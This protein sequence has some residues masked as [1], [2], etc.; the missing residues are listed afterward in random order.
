MNQITQKLKEAL[1]GTEYEN[2]LYLVG[3]AIRDNL[4][5][6]THSKDLDFVT[7]RN[8][9][10]LAEF[11]YSINLSDIQPVVYPRFGTAMIQIDG[12]SV[13]LVTA[14]SEKYQFDSRK[15][16][17]TPGTYEDDAL[18]RDF[19][20]NTLMVNIFDGTL[21]DPLSVGLD[22][23]KEGVLDTPIDA[24]KTFV[25]D[26]LRMLRAIRFKNKF[27]LDPSNAVWKA[28][29]QNAERLK[30]ISAERIQEE[31]VKMLALP[32]STACLM[33]LMNTGLLGQ[34]APEFLPLQGLE[35]G[36]FHDSDAWNHTLR[37][38]H[39]VGNDD[40]V[41]CLAALM[42]DIAKPLTKSVDEAGETHFYRHEIIGAEVARRIL[43]RLKFSNDIVDEVCLLI[44]NHMRLSTRERPGKSA[45]RRLIRDL[46][47]NLDRLILLAKADR[48]AHVV[49]VADSKGIQRIYEVICEV[50]EETPIKTL[51]SPIDGVE[52]MELLGI[53]PG[54]EV[55]WIKN[56][57][58][59]MV[60]DG[61]LLYEDKERAKE[62]AKE[63]YEN[64]VQVV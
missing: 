15:P 60:L 22:H 27:D 37:V 7:T 30:M 31:L 33:D 62:L 32:K 3:G 8:A 42:H 54:K 18:R 57:L 58:T 23:L 55:G 6:L 19:T 48:G 41:L 40:L 16:D 11:L 38:V 51:Q 12:V 59:E 2:E 53:G 61:T 44:R 21:K 29:T 46:D 20:I 43:R 39:N 34:F 47:T 5:G 17:V 14:R 36:K 9:I 25:D 26:P 50:R 13:E 4:L 64:P 1:T 56:T 52:I 63:F 49:N 10:H 24:N 35:Q 28:I 45:I